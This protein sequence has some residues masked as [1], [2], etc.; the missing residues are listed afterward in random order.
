M[1]S[2]VLDHTTD[3][4][5][6]KRRLSRIRWILSFIK[7]GC[8]KLAASISNHLYMHSRISKRFMAA[9]ALIS[10]V[11]LAVLPTAA[12]AF[13]GAEQYWFSGEALRLAGADRYETATK[14]SEFEFGYSGAASKIIVA[15]GENFPDALVA[16]PLASLLNAPLILTR[17]DSLPESAS[18]NIKWVFD[19]IDDAEPDVYLI[20]G[21]NAI[22]ESVEQAIKDLHPNIDVVRFAGEN[23]VDTSLLVA[24]QFELS[25]SVPKTVF[26]VNG[27]NF[28]DALSASGPASDRGVD[29]DL[30]PIL[31]NDSVDS[32]NPNLQTWL[33][34]RFSID[35]IKNIWLVGG[36]AVIGDAIYTQLGT[37]ASMH[38][39]SVSYLG[40]AGSN[41]YET[42]IKVADQFYGP[43]ITSLGVAS[44]ETFADALVGGQDSGKSFISNNQ[45][46]FIITHPDAVDSTLLQFLTQ[47][48]QALTTA[49]VYGGEQ[50]VSNTVVEAIE[51]Y[52]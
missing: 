12:R 11:S 39:S 33:E 6:G 44:G 38:G 4:R 25:A 47:R 2:L 35:K 3:Y 8:G 22:S 14:V 20:G 26:I 23:R 40:L 10:I 13:V 52:L 17:K 30:S 9:M 37:L 16:G 29:Y 46:A 27:S 43:N 31:L 1:Y 21:K 24:G 42:S 28:A 15:S 48:A 41:R 19:G 36:S 5:A 50:A 32:L 49:V 51:S 7:D 45:Q 34:T 18:K